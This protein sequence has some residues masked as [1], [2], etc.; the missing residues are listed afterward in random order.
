MRYQ[1]FNEF[2]AT[3]HPQ[4]KVFDPPRSKFHHGSSTEVL[5]QDLTK[6]IWHPVINKKTRP[7]TIDLKVSIGETMLNTSAPE[8]YITTKSVSPHQGL[9]HASKK[10]KTIKNNIINNKKT[11]KTQ[12]N[13]KKHTQKLQKNKPNKTALLITKNKTNKTPYDLDLMSLKDNQLFNQILN[14]TLV[15]LEIKTPKC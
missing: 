6:E 9:Y 8:G 2:S 3:K 11:K 12:K 7:Q 4:T 1:F 5:L 10:A 15:T 14:H 13:K